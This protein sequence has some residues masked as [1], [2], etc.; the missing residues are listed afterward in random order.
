MKPI[1]AAA[2]VCGTVV[3][4]GCS[5][6]TT[7]P[8]V[9]QQW[10]LPAENTSIAV[11]DLLPPGISVSGSSFSMNVDPFTATV[12]LGTLCPPCQNGFTASAPPFD[13]TFGTTQSLPTDVVGAT[14]S[15]GSVDVSI[16]NGLSF[17]PIAGG[18]SMT[19]T[20]SNAADGAVM[21]QVVLD[22]ATDSLPPGATVVRT[23]TL[24]PS[25]VDSSVALTTEV[26]STG[27]QAADM[28]TSSQISVG[29]TPAPILVSSASID[30]SNRT[31]H[32]QP[33]SLDVGNI[34]SSITDHILNGS[35][36]VD[37]TNPFAVGFGGELIIDYPGGQLSK[38]LDVPSSTSSSTSVS[39]SMEELQ[40]FL[41]QDGVSASGTATVASDAGVVTLTPGEHIDIQTKI[42]LTLQI[43]G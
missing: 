28:N 18:G 27:G 34:D 11:D 31:L 12:M 36:E 42:H 20:L 22:G 35:I 23:L 4:A 7:A 17:D 30:V 24:S 2:A 33:V 19:I 5:I 25:T 40:Q 10:I 8:K 14:I 26:V 15:S 13:W 16:Q 43:G 6:P 1:R 29:V 39:Y 32:I 9:D 38:A 41:G 37:V 3:L 21:G